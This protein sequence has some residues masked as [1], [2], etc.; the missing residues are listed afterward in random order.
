VGDDV[1]NDCAFAKT[2]GARAVR[3]SVPGVEPYVP[4]GGGG[5]YPGDPSR[6]EDR[7]DL[8]ELVDATVESVAEL[9][10]L[11]RRWEAGEE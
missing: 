5:S 9:P 11:F 3:V 4:G 6:G 7:L 8:D 10:D 2:F 1:V